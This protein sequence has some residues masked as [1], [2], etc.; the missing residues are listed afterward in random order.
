MKSSWFKRHK[1]SIVLSYYS[2]IKL[3]KYFPKPDLVKMCRKRKFLAYADD[4]FYS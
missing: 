2:T 1:K 4:F 3:S